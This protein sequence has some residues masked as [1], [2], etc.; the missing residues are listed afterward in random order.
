MFTVEAPAE[1]LL[2]DG[3]AL[4]S[5]NFLRNL[6]RLWAGDIDDGIF[7][8][9]SATSASSS[10]DNIETRAGRRVERVIA[11]LRP[12]TV[13]VTLQADV[14]T[15]GEPELCQAGREGVVDGVSR[16]ACMH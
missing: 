1:G 4:P 8:L 9:H 3:E 16:M 14:T 5:Q 2:G 11:V 12:P 13:Q 10:G 7:S 15:L 6:L